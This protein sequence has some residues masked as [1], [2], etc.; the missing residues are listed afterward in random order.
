M[1]RG[2][3]ITFV[4]AVP[5]LAGDLGLSNQQTVVV[6]ANPVS[7]R[8]GFKRATMRMTGPILD[9]AAEQLRQEEATAAPGTAPQAAQESKPPAPPPPLPVQPKQPMKRAKRPWWRF[10]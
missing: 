1:E 3:N 7:V 9:A 6:S 4:T 2:F 8:A 10:W 5:G